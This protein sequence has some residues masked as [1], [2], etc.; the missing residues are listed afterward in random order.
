MQHKQQH[1][2]IITNYKIMANKTKYSKELIDLIMT[3]LAQGIS[4]KNTLKTHSLSWEC[5]RKWLLNVNKYPKLREMYSQAKSDGI[6]YCLSDAQNLI[7]SAVEDARHKEKV[8]LGSTHLI[9]E[10]ISLAK[11]RAEKLNAK[12]YGRNDANLKISGDNNAPL[13]VKWTS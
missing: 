6:E 7:N 11:W 8:D 3:D 12:V 5:F 4:I 9:K 1:I 10:F 13:I 2:R